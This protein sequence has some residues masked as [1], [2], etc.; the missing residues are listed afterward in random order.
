MHNLLTRP[1]ENKKDYLRILSLFMSAGCF[2][3]CLSY[4]VQL[5][6]TS[7]LLQVTDFAAWGPVLTWIL[8]LVVYPKTYSRVV[9]SWE[10]PHLWVVF[11]NFIWTTYIF[12][13][14]SEFWCI[15]ISNQFVSGRHLGI[16]CEPSL[17]SPPWH[18]FSQIPFTNNSITCK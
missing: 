14:T 18:V 3:L 6:S 16:I 8:L 15:Q 5:F 12:W 10:L 2:F 11:L 9:F 17:A 4:V 7:L 1:R 13:H